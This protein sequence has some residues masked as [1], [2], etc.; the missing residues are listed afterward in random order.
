MTTR[1]HQTARTVDW[2]ECV[3]RLQRALPM[4]QA[5]HLA[6]RIA[7][8]RELRRRIG[9][10]AAGIAAATRDAQLL[11]STGPWAAEQ[12]ASSVTHGSSDRLMPKTVRYLTTDNPR[13]VPGLIATALQG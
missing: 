6:E 12:P 8:M 5:T 2:D 4:W 7:L 1:T 10:E 3:E 11:G 13:L 9:Q